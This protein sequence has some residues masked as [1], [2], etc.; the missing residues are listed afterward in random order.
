LAKTDEISQVALMT[1]ARSMLVCEVGVGEDQQDGS[2]EADNVCEIAAVEGRVF[3][4]WC[5][6]LLLLCGA[7]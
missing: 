2:S 3:G 6:Q 7:W 4:A 5:S 1:Y